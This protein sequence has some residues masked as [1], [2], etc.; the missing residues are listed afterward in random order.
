MNRP[1]LLHYVNKPLCKDN[2]KDH[3]QQTDSLKML[4]LVHLYQ[5]CSRKKTHTVQHGF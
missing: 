1:A 3:S 2:P 4:I 5:L